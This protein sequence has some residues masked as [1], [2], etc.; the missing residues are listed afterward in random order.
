[1]ARSTTTTTSDKF[2]LVGSHWSCCYGIPPGLS[3]V[4][5][6]KLRD[7]QA[8]LSPTLNPLRVEGTFHVKEIK[9]E[10]FTMAIYSMTDAVATV[11]EY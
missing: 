11:I 1:M 10:G 3:D 5:D 7:D 4:V 2:G 9:R 8:G 6:V